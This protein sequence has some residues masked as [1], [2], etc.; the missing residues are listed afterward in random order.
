MDPGILKSFYHSGYG[1]FSVRILL[2]A[3]E[4]VDKL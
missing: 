2:V 1:Q 3:Q 4:V